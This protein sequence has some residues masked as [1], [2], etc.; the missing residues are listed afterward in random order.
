MCFMLCIVQHVQVQPSPKPQTTLFM[1]AQPTCHVQA[2]GK[3]G[4]KEWF[5]LSSVVVVTGQFVKS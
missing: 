3:K 2:N 4:A 5:S 1:Q